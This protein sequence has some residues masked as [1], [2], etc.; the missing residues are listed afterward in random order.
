MSKCFLYFYNK[1][2]KVLN[3]VPRYM[4][5][6]PAIDILIFTVKTRVMCTLFFAKIEPQS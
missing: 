3:C 2:Q 4:Y 1:G 5:E 6:T